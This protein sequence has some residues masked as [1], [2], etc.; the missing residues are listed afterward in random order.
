[1]SFFCSFQLRMEITLQF[2]CVLVC[3]FTVSFSTPELHCKFFSY[4]DIFFMALG[5]RFFVVRLTLQLRFIFFRHCEVLLLITPQLG[6]LFV[7]CG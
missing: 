6:C 3:Q 1:M 5:L 4:N 2:C 7:P